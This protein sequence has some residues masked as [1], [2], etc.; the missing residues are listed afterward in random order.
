MLLQRFLLAI[1]RTR[2]KYRIALLA[3][4]AGSFHDLSPEITLRIPV[5]AVGQTGGAAASKI[6]GLRFPSR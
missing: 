4:F 6:E 1:A 3:F 5:I 2:L